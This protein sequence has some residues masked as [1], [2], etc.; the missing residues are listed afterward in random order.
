[1]APPSPAPSAPATPPAAPPPAPSTA[2]SSSPAPAAPAP[3]KPPSPPAAKAVECIKIQATTEP[4][5]L[6]EEGRWL[7]DHYPRWTQKGQPLTSGAGNQH[8]DL[9]DLVSPTGEKLKI[10]FDISSFFGKF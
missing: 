4:A 8:F 9:V 6:K 10:C 1:M 3:T 7:H 5:G 2:A